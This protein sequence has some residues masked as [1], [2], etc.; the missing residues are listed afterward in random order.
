MDDQTTVSVFDE[1]IAKDD[2]VCE[3][4]F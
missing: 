1:D 4:K 2:L 3:G